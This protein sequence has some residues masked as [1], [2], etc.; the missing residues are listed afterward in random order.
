[1]LKTRITQLEADLEKRHQEFEDEVR[2]KDQEFAAERQRRYQL[3]IEAS[4]LY[5]TLANIRELDKVEADL[6]QAQKALAPEKSERAAIEAKLS[7]T[8][9]SSP[10]LLLNEVKVQLNTLQGSNGALEDLLR[11]ASEELQDIESQLQSEKEGKTAIEQQLESM[12]ETFSTTRLELNRLKAE[13]GAEKRKAMLAQK[14][15]RITEEQVL[16]IQQECVQMHEELSQWDQ[17][18]QKIMLESE[19]KAVERGSN[20]VASE[21]R[22]RWNRR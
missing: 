6:K 10:H 20:K 21:Q 19:Q 15:A 22:G 4:D 5:A 16:F 12:S 1:M 9:S 2:K 17:R 8:L 13:L 7:E 11:D 3:E 18:V 14:Q